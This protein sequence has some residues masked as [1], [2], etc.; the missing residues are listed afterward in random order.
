VFDDATITNTASF[1][2]EEAS[3]SQGINQMILDKSHSNVD[4]EN[5]TVEW[6][7][8][9]N[10]DGYEM[11]AVEIDDTF[12]NEGLTIF[13][14]TFKVEGLPEGADYT[15]E[16]KADGNGFNITDFEDGDDNSLTIT[17]PFTI[18]FTLNYEVLHI[19]GKTFLSD[20]A[21]A[22]VHYVY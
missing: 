8:E 5:K 1:S 4:Y 17:K 20:P 18:S 15:Y 2:G 11:S 19:F 16:L 7:I 21:N 13:E 3:A 10:R 22:D 14:D 9:I 6:L 12:T